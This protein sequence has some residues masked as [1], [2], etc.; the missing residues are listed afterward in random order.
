[1]LREAEKAWRNWNPLIW[2]VIRYRGCFGEPP[3]A[4]PITQARRAGGPCCKNCL[5]CTAEHLAQ[6]NGKGLSAFSCQSGSPARGRAPL[7][8]VHFAAIPVVAG[9]LAG[10]GAVAAYVSAP[11]NL[12]ATA[13]RTPAPSAELACAAQTWPYIDPACTPSATIDPKRTVRLVMPTRSS[14]ASETNSNPPVSST[15]SA[16]TARAAEPGLTTSDTVLRQ[17]QQVATVQIEPGPQAA[18]PRAKRGET[19]RQRDRRRAAQ[20]YQPGFSR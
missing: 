20:S 14:E 3:K 15:T 17:P 1:M 8:T 7:A 18:R 10:S 6:R 9:L 19:R 5:R 13:I 16:A 4:E 2:G 12:P 11:S